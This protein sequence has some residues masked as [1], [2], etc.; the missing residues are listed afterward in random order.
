[1]GKLTYD[2]VHVYIPDR[3][4]HHLQVVMS[5]KLRRGE[6]FTFTWREDPSLGH[7]R[8]TVWVT[9]DSTLVFKYDDP[10]RPRLNRRWLEELAYLANSNDGL[11][12]VPEP[13]EDL[14][15]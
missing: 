2:G 9:A 14:D 15:E 8:M 11:H 7:G 1:M 12:L 5:D 3:A 4:L 6:S 10:R 13:E